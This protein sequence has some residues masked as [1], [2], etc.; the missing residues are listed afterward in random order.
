MAARQDHERENAALSDNRM[1]AILCMQYKRV[2]EAYHSA[3]K[4]EPMTDEARLAC[5]H[6]LLEE[7]KR[8]WGQLSQLAK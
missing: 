7:R 8:I 2:L 5:L 3:E 4:W 1:L 6:A